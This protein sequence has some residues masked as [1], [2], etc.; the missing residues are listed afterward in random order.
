MEERRPGQNPEQD[1]TQDDQKVSE[2]AA[3]ATHE[4]LPQ[5]RERQLIEEGQK[6]AKR[7]QDELTKDGHGN[8]QGGEGF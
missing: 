6:R 4:A 7:D 8:H 2:R 3:P 1:R 5:G